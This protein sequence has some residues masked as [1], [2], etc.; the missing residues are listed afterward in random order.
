[1]FLSIKEKS[2]IYLFVLMAVLFFISL[3]SCTDQKISS[4]G[5]EARELVISRE[6]GGE[7]ASPP[8]FGAGEHVY[9]RF[10]ISEYDL[11]SDGNAWIQEDLTMISS[12]G[13]V[14]LNEPNIIDERVKPPKGAEWWLV[15]NK[16]TLPEV[17]EPGNVTIQI[18]VRDK[19]GGGTLYIKTTV[20]VK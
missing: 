1:M 20:E 5:L 9:I 15:N 3:I 11:A 8:L 17:I 4:F 6:R 19:I 14:I 12:G 18:N 2:P 10:E 7:K 16:I 13:K